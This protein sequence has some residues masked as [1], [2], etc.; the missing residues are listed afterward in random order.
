MPTYIKPITQN[1][2]DRVQRGDY[3][4]GDFIRDPALQGLSAGQ[5]ILVRM[6]PEN[7]AKV[8]AKLREIKRALTRGT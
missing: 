3:S 2:V 7:E 6:G 5:K 8:K 1:V 4:Q